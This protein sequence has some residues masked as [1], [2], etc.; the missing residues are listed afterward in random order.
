MQMAHVE[1]WIRE[2]AYSIW[3]MEGRPEGRE[4]Q[5][6]EQATRDVMSR[7]KGSSADPIAVKTT[8]R[9]AAAAKSAPA[10][11]RTSKARRSAA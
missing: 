6:W 10:K 7:G 11:G 3:E 8:G 2:R 1:T 5:H 9:P 4:R